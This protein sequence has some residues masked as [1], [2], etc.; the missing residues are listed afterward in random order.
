MEEG[1]KD[2]EILHSAPHQ[3]PVGRVDEVSAARHPKLRWRPD[4][5]PV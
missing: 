4:P 3:A 1:A 5:T 2:A